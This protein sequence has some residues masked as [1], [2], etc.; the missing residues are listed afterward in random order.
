VAA[1]SAVVRRLP[2]RAV[3]AT[4]RRLGRLW[5]ALDRRHLEV[6][7]ANLRRAFPDWSEERVQ[8]TARGV[9]AHFGT[10]LLDLLWMQGRPV[11]D[12]VALCDYDGAEHVRAPRDAGRGVLCP[13]AHF[14][15]WELQAMA[16]VPRT[17]HISMIA[18]PLDNPALDRRL[19]RLRTA[20]GNTVFYKQKA[21]ARVLAALRDGD[22]VAILIDQNVQAK[23]G[24]FVRFFGRPAATTTVAAAVALKTGCAIVPVHCVLL[25]SGRYRMVYGPPVEWAGTGRRDEDVAAL[26]QHLT[27]VIEGWVRENPEQWLWLHRRWKTQ[28]SSEGAAAAPGPEGSGPSPSRSAN[29][30]GNGPGPSAPRATGA[31]REHPEHILIRAPNWVGDV[32]LSLPALRDVR[33]RFPAARLEVLARPWVAE[34]YR[35]LPEADAVSESR[36][37]AADVASL[38]GRFD[39]GILLPNSFATALVLW[40]AGVP[41]RWGYA[42]DG[43]GLL[44]TRRCRVPP[45]VRGRS[46]VYYYRAMLEGL[47]FAVEGDPDASL[48]CPDEWAARGRALLGEDGPWVGVNPGAFYGTAK[49]WAPERFAAAADLVA[50]RTG[51][52]VAIVGAAAERR[53]GEAVADGLRAPSRVLCGETTLGELVGVVSGLDLLLTNDSGP[54]HLAAALGTPLVAVFGPTDW[55]E[56]APATSRARLVREDVEC[57]PCRLRECPIDHRCM[58]RVGVDRVVAAALELLES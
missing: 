24:I 14:G 21:I 30:A 48:A 6:A 45:R 17:G 54:M 8:A 44:L 12:L 1:V 32:V 43:R 52:K 26:T 31:P 33:T 10:V 55:T 4:G 49:R 2:R 39:L 13:S 46:Q 23:D 38:R 5:G 57:S 11:E 51:A 25:P 3:L 35:A 7:A 27:T 53:L 42:T 15:N 19:V 40:R 9:Y 37:H 56:T 36:G 22:V 50:R 29:I 28:P 58:A 20:G 16:S 34:L 18:R 41:E 47:G